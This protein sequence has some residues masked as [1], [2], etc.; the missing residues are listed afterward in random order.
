LDIGLCIIGFAHVPQQ[1]HVDT[2]STCICPCF[3]GWKS[4]ICHCDHHTTYSKPFYSKCCHYD[5]VFIIFFLNMWLLYTYM[6]LA[7]KQLIC[8]SEAGGCANLWIEWDTD[9]FYYYSTIYA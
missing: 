4:V 6:Q 9:P 1:S 2:W 3:C 7:T 8:L 5:N